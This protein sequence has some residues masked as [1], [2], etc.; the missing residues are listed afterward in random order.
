MT[1][2]MLKPASPAQAL[3]RTCADPTP[4]AGAQKPSE[5]PAPAQPSHRPRFEVSARTATMLSSLR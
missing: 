1:A 2:N 3:T 4:H 5:P